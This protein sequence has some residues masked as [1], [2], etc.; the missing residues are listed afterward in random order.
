MRAMNKETSKIRDRFSLYYNENL[1]LA[2]RRA[3][4]ELRFRTSNGVKETPRYHR[5]R[6]YPFSST[7][8]RTIPR[9][10]LVIGLFLVRYLPLVCM[11]LAMVPPPNSRILY[12]FCFTFS[13]FR[14]SFRQ[15][16]SATT[17]VLLNFF[18]S[19]LLY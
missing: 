17:S 14:I 5:R 1:V 13:Q 7:F 16:Y 9:S 6:Y 15:F 8:R 2:L 10:G 18:T 11:R 12:P 19:K 4:N 3:R